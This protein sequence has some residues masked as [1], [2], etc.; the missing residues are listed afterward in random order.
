MHSN[1]LNDV[2]KKRC[3]CTSAAWL[4][5]TRYGY[6]T[7]PEGSDDPM[8][9]EALPDE[10]RDPFAALDQDLFTAAVGEET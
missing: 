3:M 2:S 7:G 5:R 4:A 10:L 1:G 9:Y 8:A 6:S